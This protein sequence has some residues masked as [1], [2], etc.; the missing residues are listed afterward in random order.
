MMIQPA[1]KRFTQTQILFLHC[2]R[3]LMCENDTDNK[4]HT[5][6]ISYNSQ[7]FKL[8]QISTQ[9][10]RQ[11]TEKNVF[12]VGP[13]QLLPLS[14][15]NCRNWKILQSTPHTEED[16][17]VTPQFQQM[18]AT[19][20][21]ASQYPYKLQCCSNRDQVLGYMKLISVREVQFALGDLIPTDIH[22]MLAHLIT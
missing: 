1:V 12:N 20:T 5:P 3:L 13:N 9:S 18:T 16:K 17:P 21:M 15:G 6:S 10:S 2:S 8:S 14:S 22:L 7:Q 11:Y 4:N 19:R